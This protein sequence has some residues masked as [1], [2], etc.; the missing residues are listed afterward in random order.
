[1]LT[2]DSETVPEEKAFS[3]LITEK[4]DAE[5]FFDSVSIQNYDDIKDTIED[6]AGGETT[7]IILNAVFTKCDM[8]IPV[9]YTV[10]V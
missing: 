10:N 2:I 4:F 5:G 8:I 7:E 9:S 6:F 3:A 1:M